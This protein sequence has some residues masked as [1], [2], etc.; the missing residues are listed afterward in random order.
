MGNNIDPESDFIEHKEITFKGKNNKPFVN[1]IFNY[2]YENYV[3]N[4]KWI[5]KINDLYQNESFMTLCDIYT[6]DLIY[7]D[8]SKYIAKSVF[9]NRRKKNL[10]MSTIS[11]EK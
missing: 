5:F 2:L 11:F 8:M 9:W 10:A 4:T 6:L 3:I 7:Q 1:F